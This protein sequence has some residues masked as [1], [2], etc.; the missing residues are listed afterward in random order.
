MSGRRSGRL[1]AGERTPA[2]SK[3][4]LSDLPRFLPPQFGIQVFFALS[5]PDMPPKKIG[6]ATDAQERHPVVNRKRIGGR[7]PVQSKEKQGKMAELG[8]ETD[9]QDLVLEPPAMAEDGPEV[10]MESNRTEPGTAESGQEE[11][12]EELP[13]TGESKAKAKAK[14]KAKAKTKAPSKANAMLGAKKRVTDGSMKSK[15][16]TPQGNDVAAAK[17]KAQAKPTWKALPAE[18]PP[19]DLTTAEDQDAALFGLKPNSL[20]YQRLRTALASQNAKDCGLQAVAAAIKAL[21]HNANKTQLD[22]E[23]AQS[24]RSTTA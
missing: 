1:F 5:S 6:V 18:S 16:R 9:G 7:K 23:L 15:T 14:G 19:I 22:R 10:F 13:A 8:P 12:E 17:G 11:E 2:E 20:D 21:P 24:R 3:I 4:V